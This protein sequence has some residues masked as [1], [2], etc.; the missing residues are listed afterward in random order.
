[1][2]LPKSVDTNI[3]YKFSVINWIQTL[4]L[5]M[6]DVRLLINLI[7]VRINLSPP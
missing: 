5:S 3:Q 1:M 2:G 6:S 7:V 4:P